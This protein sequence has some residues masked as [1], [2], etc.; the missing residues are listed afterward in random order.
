M[1]VSCEWRKPAR[2]IVLISAFVPRPGPNLI[3]V[4][5]A[6]SG[7]AEAVQLVTHQASVLCWRSGL[8]EPIELCAR[9]VIDPFLNLVGENAGNGS[10]SRS[11]GDC[12]VR[13]GQDFGRQMAFQVPM[14]RNAGPGCL[15]FVEI[16]RQV[17]C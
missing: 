5:L 6:V 8:A 4:K 10:V 15:R 1:L 11:L 9:E 17:W 7:P 14:L 16:G 12:V 13:R 2:R 3:L